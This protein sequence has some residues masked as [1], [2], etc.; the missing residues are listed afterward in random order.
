MGIIEDIEFKE[1]EVISNPSD[2]LEEAS[3]FLIIL[4]EISVYQVIKS[5]YGVVNKEIKIGTLNSG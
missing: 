5:E 2:N 4:G 1:N 3:L